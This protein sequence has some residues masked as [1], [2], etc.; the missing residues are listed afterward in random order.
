[1]KFLKTFESYK[2]MYKKINEDNNT[3]AQTSD[4]DVNKV[5]YKLI[6][7]DASRESLKCEYAVFYD[8]KEF[9]K[10]RVE[11]RRSGDIYK[12]DVALTKPEYPVKGKFAVVVNRK[13]AKSG[14]KLVLK[15]MITPIAEGN[16]GLYNVELALQKRISTDQTG[17]QPI[18]VEDGFEFDSATLKPESITKIKEALKDAD[19]AKMPVYKVGASQDGNPDEMI[20][21]DKTKAVFGDK[22]VKRKDWDFHLVT[23][24]YKS[25]DAILKEVGF[26]ETQGIDKPADANDV[27]NIYGK[28]DTDLKSAKNRNIS[29]QI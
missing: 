17:K 15:N 13:D 3:Q 22:Q 19:K 8:G 6:V 4:F 28:F 14:A 27:K 23:E 24:R 12:T 7:V 29:I 11:I 21:N 5:E 26:K 2:K 10:S 9:T 20:Q 16:T 1:M 25:V 18:I